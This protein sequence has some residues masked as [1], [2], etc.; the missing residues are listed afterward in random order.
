AE[1]GHLV[2]G[3]LHTSTAPSTVDRIIDQFAADRQAQIRTMLS[4]SLK[5]VIAQVLCK[6][7][8]GGRVAAYEI[9]IGTPASGDLI[10]EGKTFQIPGI[11]Q[12]SRNV[13]MCTMNDSLMD[14]A[15]RGIIE[16]R[17]AYTKSVNKS[18]MRT[19]MQ[20]AQMEIPTFS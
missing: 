4:E 13:G 17:E 6:K 12:T 1:T 3:T 8:G 2:F 7:I 16:P 10:R 20:Q 11:M 19:L 15:K 18:E 9:L 5:G 14:L